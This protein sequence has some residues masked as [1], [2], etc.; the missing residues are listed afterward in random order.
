MREVEKNGICTAAHAIGEQG[1]RN[2]VVAG[3]RTIKHGTFLNDET[4]AL[5][6]ETGTYLVTT[7]TAFNTLK[8]GVLVKQ[9]CNTSYTFTIHWPEAIHHCKNAVFGCYTIQA[10]SFV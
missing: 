7:L 8:Y 9:N 2:A 1:C 6:A 4:I 10:H 5:M 3:I